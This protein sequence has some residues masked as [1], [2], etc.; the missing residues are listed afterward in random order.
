VVDREV[1][2]IYTL[3]AVGCAAIFFARRFAYW[4][5]WEPRTFRVIGIAL[6]TLGVG[7]VWSVFGPASAVTVL[8]GSALVTG[9]YIRQDIGLERAE[10]EREAR[11]CEEAAGIT[12]EDED[13]DRE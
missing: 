1:R 9:I 5:D 13:E 7:G 2:G 4:Q 10:L 3:F 8:L 12:P 11:E 6:L